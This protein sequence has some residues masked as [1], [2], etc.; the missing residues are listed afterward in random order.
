MC[1]CDCLIVCLFGCLF[2]VCGCLVR[3]GGQVKTDK[4]PEDPGVARAW[5][6]ELTKVSSDEQGKGTLML[7]I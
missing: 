6:Q 2:V 5:C 1:V 7:P 3:K 4:V